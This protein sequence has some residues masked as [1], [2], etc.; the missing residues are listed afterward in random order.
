MQ[1]LSQYFWFKWLRHKTSHEL[2][3]PSTPGNSSTLQNW[4]C[5]YIDRKW[6]QSRHRSPCNQ[7]WTSYCFECA[8][9]AQY[10]SMDTQ[11]HKVINSFHG[12]DTFIF[13]YKGGHDIHLAISHFGMNVMSVSIIF[14]IILDSKYIL[15]SPF[16]LLHKHYFIRPC[17]VSFRLCVLFKLTSGWNSK[18]HKQ[19]MLAV[20]TPPRNKKQMFTRFPSLSMSLIIYEAGF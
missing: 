15:I 17:Y 11:R 10:T 2:E 20:N 19:V 18:M 8:C 5:G 9:T 1:P 7:R 4:W 13:K 14:D 16:S 6:H 12:A 3:L